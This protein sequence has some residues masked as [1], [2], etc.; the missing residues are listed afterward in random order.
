[1]CFVHFTVVVKIRTDQTESFINK[2]ITLDCLLKLPNLTS[3]LYYSGVIT[4]RAFCA[5]RT[6]IA[7]FTNISNKM[8]SLLIVLIRWIFVTKS[9]LVIQ[10]RRR[11]I[12]VGTLAGTSACLA[13]SLTFYIYLNK[14]K[15]ANYWHCYSGEKDAF[16]MNK[17]FM[18]FINWF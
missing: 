7:V 15:N 3:I 2:F 18:L 4:S 14:E 5:E 16:K 10:P 8:V 1:M 13:L 12:L 11:R 9:Y 17:S 6:S